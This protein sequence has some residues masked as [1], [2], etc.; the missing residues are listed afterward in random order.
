MAKK[1]KSSAQ[2]Q[3]AKLESNLPEIAKKYKIQIS[4]PYGY[5]PDD[6]DKN[7][8]KLESII[9]TKE[10]EYNQLA[11]E[12]KIR[13]LRIQNQ[14]NELSQKDDIIQQLENDMKALKNTMMQLKMQLS[15]MEVPDTTAIEDMVMTEK[16]GTITGKQESILKSPKDIVKDNTEEQKR[17]NF[18]PMDQLKIVKGDTLNITTDAASPVP[19]LNKPNTSNTTYKSIKNLKVVKGD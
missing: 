13:E 6:V 18:I 17:K 16:I 1:K 4:Y 5:Y 2:E 19:E 8:I 12:I 3:A 9:E 10:N 14:Q 7:I 11:K 15:L